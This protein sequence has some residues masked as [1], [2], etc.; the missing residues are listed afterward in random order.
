MKFTGSSK[1][2]HNESSMKTRVSQILE[3][4]A[5]TVFTGGLPCGTCSHPKSKQ[6]N[7]D[8]LEFIEIKKRGGTKMPWAAFVKLALKKQYNYNLTTNAL[9][10]HVRKCLKVEAI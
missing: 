5:D 10:K 9:T 6:I 7:A 1:T 8:C 3:K 2:W 4:H